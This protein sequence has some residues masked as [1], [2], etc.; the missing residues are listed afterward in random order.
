MDT[1]RP[2]GRAANASATAGW[3]SLFAMTV[4]LAGCGAGA[5]SGNSGNNISVSIANKV[6]TL[7]AGTVAVVFLAAV[8]NDSSNSGVSWSLTANGTACSPACGT[9]SLA[10]SSTVT[11]T[12]PA[13]GPSAPNNQPTLTA[14]SVAK[15]NKSDTDTFIITAALTVSITN[16]FVSVNTGASPFVVDATVQNDSTNSGVSWALTA[17]GAACTVAC[18]A[19][20]GATT[21]NVTYESPTSVPSSQL[22]LTATS[23]HDPSKT[24][25]FT[26]TVRT[27][28]IIVTIQGKFNSVIAGSSNIFLEANVVNDT[29]SNPAVTWTLTAG[30]TNC[31]PAC[32]TL[33]P[34]GAAGVQ[35]SPPTSVPTAPAG[36]NTPTLTATS[37][38]D[39]TKSDSDTFTITAAPPISV[40]ITKLQSILATGNGVEFSAYVQ[41]DFSN[42]GVTWTLTCT[43]PATSCGTLTP[44]TSTTTATYVPSGP[45]PAQATVTATSQ[46]NSAK[47]DS[48]VINVTS[49]V[50]NACG[51]AG[52]AESLLNGH[53][54]LLLEGFW[55]GA[56]GVPSLIAA[57]FQADGTGGITAGEED[58]NDSISPQH[59]TF[60][61]T[62]SLYTAGADHRGC[63][64]LTNSG[65]TTSVFHFALGGINSGV[66][67]EG[68]VIEFDDSSGNGQGSRGS[69]ILRQQDP[70]SF[71]LTALQSQYAFGVDGWTQ[72]DQFSRLAGAGSFTN[73]GGSLNGVDDLVFSGG[74]ASP[75]TTGLTGNINVVTPTTGRTTGNFDIFNWAIYIVN[76]AQFF[77][78]GTDPVS[79][80]TVS[81]GR[82]IGTGPSFT[83][84]SLS[85]NYVVH[86]TGNSSG[87][88]DVNLELLTMTPGGAQAGT[89][90]GTVY[91]YGAGNGAQTATLSGVT[92]NVDA[93]S[94]RTVLGNPGDNLPVLYLTTPTDGVA[95][96]VVGVGA[97]AL[98]GMAEPQT[99]TALPAGTY[100]FGTEDPSDNT[101]P[102]KAGVETIA[103]G[104]AFNSTFDQSTTSALP[105]SGQTVSGTVSLGPN[106]TGNIGPSTVAITSGSKLFS[107]DESGGTSGPAAIV[108]AEQ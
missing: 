56:G 98:F 30:N 20:S 14:T 100:I 96:F 79:N 97:D 62:G 6:T 50:T 19:L 12:P 16:K 57:S 61:S 2:F 107:I 58:V 63:L 5:G 21:T 13:S 94:G 67:S 81:V 68:R 22:T 49:S 26:F 89:L 76:S 23:V 80:G 40:T 92:Y 69:G 64:Q 105:Q 33:T 88:A 78:I 72:S 99:G 41:N 52:G 10:T 59:L 103:S 36:Y 86:A 28:A 75:D 47:S 32:G 15:T 51:S 82:V 85:G 53:Y 24:D 11:Y 101:V 29:S 84:S 8:Q 104:G 70:N 87:I 66:A 39:A 108:V 95:A 4:L 90:G 17:N 37:K 27:A 93:G 54:A 25:S 34:I 42:S 45:A 18:G 91:S 74:I 7:Q 102:N 46:A 55:S 44:G 43:P 60:T 106:G 38:V 31:Q 3:Y 71:V 48:S 73:S 83:A 9:L 35:Y 65:G 77:V 1:S